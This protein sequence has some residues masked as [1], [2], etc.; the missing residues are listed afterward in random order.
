M[1]KIPKIKDLKFTA[2]FKFSSSSSVKKKGPDTKEASRSFTQGVITGSKEV[3][4]SLPSALNR[5]MEMPIWG[6]F[7]PKTAYLRKNG[8]LATSGYRDLIDSGRLA[9]S[10]KLSTQFLKTKVNTKITYTAPYAGLVYHGGAIRPYGN[11][12]ASMVILPARPWIDAAFGEGDKGSTP[13]ID[14]NE[15]YSKAIDQ[16]WNAG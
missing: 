3:E 7:S 14:I 9:D 4:A 15:I 5:A 8:E 1:A 13:L 10:L 6:P 16:A 12:S 2:S 11:P